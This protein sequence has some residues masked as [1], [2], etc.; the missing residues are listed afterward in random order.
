MI[1][2]GK[3]GQYTLSFGKVR[4]PF[5]IEFS[6]RK[7]LTIHV[8]P[9]MRLEVLAPDDRD[10]AQVLLRVDKRASWIA[11]QLRYFEQFQPVA[12]P[13]Q[14]V[15]GETHLYLGRQYRLKVRKQTDSSVK[16]VGRFLQVH[17]T[18]KED[19]D[20]IEELVMDW[21]RQHAVALFARRL[22]KCLKDCKTLHLRKT[23]TLVVRRMTRSWGRCDKSGN[24]SLNVDLVKTPIHCIDYVITHELCHI[25]IHSHSPAFYRLLSRVMPEWEKRKERLDLFRLE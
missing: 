15:T 17:H 23:P 6:K 7:Q 10:I 13:R 9:D 24:I 14:Y 16:L 11:K 19:R 2:N 12:T 8:H 4:I 3:H 5:E 1:E 21:Y 18:D 20:A 22:Q 25:N